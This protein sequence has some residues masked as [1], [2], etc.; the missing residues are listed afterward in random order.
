MIK[1][2]TNT[3]EKPIISFIIPALNEEEELP[4][5]IAQIRSLNVIPKEVIVADG[6][7]TDNT[8]AIA[9]R[10]ADKV[11]DRHGQRNQNIAENRNKGATLAQGKYLFF[12]DC[13][14][15][16]ENFE[17]LIRKV[18]EVFEKNPRIVALTTRVRFFS[19]EENFFDRL[20]LGIINSAIRLF[21]KLGIGVSMGWVQIIRS[22]AFRQIKGYDERLIT[23]EDSDIFRR[24]NKLGKTA[25]LNDFI[26][27][28]S[29]WRFHRDGW[30]K[31][32]KRWLLNFLWYFF[33]K[34]S[35]DQRWQIKNPQ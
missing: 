4:R 27:Y 30:P 23:A 3:G 19:E 35:Y 31:A 22:E 28:G 1:K 32:I 6:G 26:A 15:I 33:A 34:R 5:T 16:I 12:L 14:V 20:I 7:S 10:S 29:A 9:R 18:M 8:V 13:D 24:L 17:E 25:C 21:N 11:Y 2:E